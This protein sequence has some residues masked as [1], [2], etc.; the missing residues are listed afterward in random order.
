MKSFSVFLG[1][2]F[3][4]DSDAN[5]IINDFPTLSFSANVIFSIMIWKEEL[6]LAVLEEHKFDNWAKW[7]SILWNFQTV[8]TLMQKTQKDKYPIEKFSKIRKFLMST[9]ME[10]IRLIVLVKYV[11]CVWISRK[12]QF[13]RFSLEFSDCQDFDPMEKNTNF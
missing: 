6:E 8:S 5:D 13:K 4:R 10:E 11:I 1:V 2:S 12:I 3:Y 7:L 9:L